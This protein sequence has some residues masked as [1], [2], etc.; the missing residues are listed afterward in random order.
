MSVNQ[1]KK[2]GAESLLTFTYTEQR[3]G[4][5]TMKVRKV[6][7]Y[8]SHNANYTVTKMMVNLSSK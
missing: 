6:I 7:N 4:S 3:H 5:V 2:K 1:K 8:T